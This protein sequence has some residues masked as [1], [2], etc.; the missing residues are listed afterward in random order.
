VATQ[1]RRS[2][3]WIGAIFLALGLSRRPSVV[4][5]RERRGDRHDAGVSAR[6][7]KVVVGLAAHDE[8]RGREGCVDG[9]R[10]R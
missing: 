9:R 8:C 7:E 4:V 5:K 6:G 1:P 10:G 2:L 3:L